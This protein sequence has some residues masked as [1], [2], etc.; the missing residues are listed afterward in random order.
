MFRSHGG[1]NERDNRVSVCA[2]HHLR[3]LH[4]RRVRAWGKAPDDITWEIGVGVGHPP[5]FRAHGDYYLC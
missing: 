5:L 4:A 2:W 3:G 1:G